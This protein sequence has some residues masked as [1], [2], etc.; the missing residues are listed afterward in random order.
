M[1]ISRVTFIF[2]IKTA[3]RMCLWICWEQSHELDLYSPFLRH[4]LCRCVQLLRPEPCWRWD[5]A[6]NTT[7]PNTHLLLY[8]WGWHSCSRRVGLEVHTNR[9]HSKFMHTKQLREDKTGLETWRSGWRCEHL[10]HREGDSLVKTW[11]Q[12]WPEPLRSLDHEQKQQPVWETGLGVGGWAP[13]E[14]PWCQKESEGLFARKAAR[15][16]LCQEGSNS[17]RSEACKS[18]GMHCHGSSPCLQSEINQC[19]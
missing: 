5:T 14:R 9:K 4:P 13:L 15:V 19:Q 1:N 6:T 7:G 8:K 16:S 10:P 2:Q 11:R 18:S 12:Q 3:S 17:W